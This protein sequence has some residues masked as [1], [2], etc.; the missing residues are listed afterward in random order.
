MVEAYVWFC[1]QPG[2]RCHW[3]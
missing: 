3:L 1:I 2:S